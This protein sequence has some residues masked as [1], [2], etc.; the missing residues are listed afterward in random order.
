MNKAALDS[1]LVA[2]IAQKEG[3]DKAGQ[4]QLKCGQK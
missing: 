1:A 4:T 2:L 3:A